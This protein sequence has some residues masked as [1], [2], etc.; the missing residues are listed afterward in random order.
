MKTTVRVIAITTKGG[1]RARMFQVKKSWVFPCGQGYSTAHRNEYLQL[2]VAP[3][4]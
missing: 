2:L 4:L 1:N 3:D